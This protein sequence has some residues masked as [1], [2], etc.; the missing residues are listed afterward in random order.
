MKN[1]EIARIFNEIAG[2]LEIKGDNPFRIRAY[3]G[4][5]LNLEGLS[6]AVDEIPEKELPEIP[7]IGKD[8]A[9]KINEYLLTGK[10]Q[11]Y[12]DLKKEVPEGLLTLLAVPGLGPKTARLLHERLDIK[13][14]DDLDRLASG[15]KLSGLP[16]IKARTEENILK[17]IAMLRRGRERRPL[18]WARPI[19]LDIIERIKKNARVSE[20][21]PAG[22]L[23]RWKETVKDI[24]ILAVSNDPKAVMNALMHLSL[25]REVVMHGPTKSSVII[26]DDMQVDLRVVERESYGAALAYFTGGKAHNIRLRE[27]AAGKGLKINEYGIFREGDNKRLGGE[28]EEDIYGTL[29]MQYVPPEMRE[30]MGE[31]EAAL[32]GRLPTVIGLEDIRGDLHVHSDWSDGAHPI[33]ELVEA[34][35]R[36]GY[37]YMAVTDHS[38]GLSVAGGLSEE[39]LIEQGREIEGLNRKLTG[40]CILRGVE[41]DIKPDGGIDISDAVLKGLDFVIASIH[42]GFKQPGKQLTDRLISA[43]K[44]PYVNAIGHPTGR[45]IGER[46][47]YDV[48]M[49]AVL[50]A[51]KET[52]TALEINAHP[53]RLDINDAYA[54]R[55]GDLGVSVVINTDTHLIDQFD[56][57][58]YGVSIAKRAWLEKRDVLNALDAAG[59]L[60]KLKKK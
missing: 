2:L 22:S 35:R 38:K 24:D 20:I 28:R 39:R 17:G 14:L 47:A 44:N 18:G 51:A 41:A 4:A 16:G 8:L 49:E 26:Q 52:G 58:I 30:D 34:A 25:V 21:E 57:M 12:E 45:L 23:R 27:M 15:H 55:A 6:R 54:R 40:F 32:E 36:R 29:G 53:L 60:K 13:D 31:V 50:K 33:V 43:M 46:E 56:H 42:S 9:H 3:R 48:D 11:A 19:A 10:V 5:A 7:G 37:S 1:R 59:L